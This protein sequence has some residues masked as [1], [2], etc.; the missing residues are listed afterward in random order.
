MALQRT[1]PARL[2]VAAWI[3]LLLGWSVWWLAPPPEGPRVTLLPVREGLAAVVTTRDA[4]MLVD[5]GRLHREA[6]EQLADLGIRR[7]EAVL[8]SHSDEDHIGGLVAVLRTV[9]VGRLLLPADMLGD[10]YA[11]PLLRAARERSVRVEPLARGLSTQVGGSR[12]VVVWPPACSSTQSENERSVVARLEIPPQ[13]LLITSDIGREIERR[14]AGVA[15]LRCGVLIVPHHGSR[16]S[17]SSAL[18]DASRPDVAL[19]PAGPGNLHH[20]P[21]PEVLARLHTRH[22]PFRAPIH[23]GTCGAYLDDHGAWRPFP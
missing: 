22:I 16:R 13:P 14:L 11:V 20:H 8:A 12:M 10:P 23:H 5:G 2:G 7:L 3:A 1:R 17:S 9:S 18:L 21:H 4:S 6:A 15:P 19:I